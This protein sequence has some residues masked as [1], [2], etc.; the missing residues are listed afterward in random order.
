MLVL[1]HVA[2]LQLSV[3]SEFED[4]EIREEAERLCEEVTMAG[5]GPGE[6]RNLRYALQVLETH[7]CSVEAAVGIGRS[8]DSEILLKTA[9]KDGDLYMV[10]P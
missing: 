3:S 10:I 6:E 7:A 9:P 5:I 8:L 2:I 4:K 1:R